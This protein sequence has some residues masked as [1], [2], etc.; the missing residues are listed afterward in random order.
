MANRSKFVKE[1][2]RDDHRSQLIKAFESLANLK[3]TSQKPDGVWGSKATIKCGDVTI[4]S[5]ELD[6]EFTIPFDDNLES[7]EGEIIIY[8]LSNRTIA[9]LKNKSKLTIEAGYEGDTGVIFSGY[10][11]KSQTKRDGAD[12]KT[13]LKVIDDI[14]EKE[15]LNLSYESGVTAQYILKDLLNRVSTPVGKI[16][17]ARD[18][19]Y[20]NSVKIDETL[21]SAIK[22]YAEVCGVSVF[23]SC[24]KL[25]ACK[26]EDVARSGY[27]EVS[28]KTGMIGS[29]EPFEETRKTEDY[30]DTIKGYEVEML[31]QH[32]MS[33]G[34]QTKL[35][36][37]QYKGTYYVMSGEHIFNESEAIT[38]VKMV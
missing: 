24:G 6:F 18:W 15:T 1:G 16:K 30:E 27:F 38:K 31:L 17:L 21:E 34:A 11:T 7:N 9:Q 29:P 25:Y 12:R 32:R 20:E 22:K 19:T 37:E 8:N 23:T 2:A 36:S 5:S 33:A 4:K 26:L 10:I 3:D 13:T 14:E 28:E 35:A